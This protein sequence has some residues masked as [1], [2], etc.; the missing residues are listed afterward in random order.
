MP[1][2]PAGV[3]SVTILSESMA[4]VAATEVGQSVIRVI[5]SAF[6][7]HAYPDATRFGR[8]V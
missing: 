6:D 4:V 7:R 3:S 2:S 1:P 8:A 5:A